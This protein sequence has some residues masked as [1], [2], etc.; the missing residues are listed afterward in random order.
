MIKHPLTPEHRKKILLE[1]VLLAFWM[2]AA[3][4]LFDAIFRAI[5]I[6]ALYEVS[7][8]YSIK[9]IF[10]GLALV[11]FGS[12][13]PWLFMGIAKKAIHYI[14]NFIS[15]IIHGDDNEINKKL[16]HMDITRDKDFFLSQNK[17]IKKYISLIFIFLILFLTVEAVM[18]IFNIMHKVDIERKYSL[19]FFVFIFVLSELFN[20]LQKKKRKSKPS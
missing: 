13:I 9:S 16:K 3:Y 4:L 10:L 1:V 17:R 8:E 15:V 5:L 14:I 2:L 20:I 12:I 18:W 6:M 7:K 19:L 11:L